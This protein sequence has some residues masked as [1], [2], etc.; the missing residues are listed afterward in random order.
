M[1]PLSATFVATEVAIGAAITIN[2][3]VIGKYCHRARRDRAR[4]SAEA[5]MD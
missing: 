3:N 5:R 1:V 2:N 4:F